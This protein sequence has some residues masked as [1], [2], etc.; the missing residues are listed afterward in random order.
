MTG[1]DKIIRPSVA[2]ARTVPTT[3]TPILGNDIHRTA[4]TISAVD[5]PVYIGISPTMAAKQGVIIA[6]SALPVTLCRCHVG[7]WVCRQIW[8]IAVGGVA[9]I[10]TIEGFELWPPSNP[11]PQS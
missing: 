2:T 7:D 3:V 6:A 4:I 1:P 11:N 5:F 10:Y 8:A 9:S